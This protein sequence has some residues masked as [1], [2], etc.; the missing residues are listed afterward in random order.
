MLIVNLLAESVFS[1]MPYVFLYAN[2][3]HSFCGKHLIL[4]NISFLCENKKFNSPTTL[5][6]SNDWTAFM[7][8][9]SLVS[10]YDQL[11]YLLSLIDCRLSYIIFLHYTLTTLFISFFLKVDSVTRVP[12]K[13]CRVDPSCNIDGIIQNSFRR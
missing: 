5:C 6:T 13:S 8:V 3:V 4:L 11:S 1:C 10:L 12:M 2:S 9:V 7:K